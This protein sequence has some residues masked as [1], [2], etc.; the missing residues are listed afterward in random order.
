MRR[1]EFITL[2]G[3]AAVT[4]IWSKAVFAQTTSISRIAALLVGDEVDS[5][6]HAWVAAIEQG[7]RTAGRTAGV[8][9]RLDYYWAG[10]DP[11][12]AAVAAALVAKASPSVII[13]VGSA[14]AIAM[15]RA[16]STIPIVFSFASDPVGQGFVSNL[17]R[18]GGNITGFSNLEP[19][20]GG[21]LLGLLKE[22]APKTARVAVMFNPVTSPHTELFERSVG[23]A[24]PSF[25]IEVTRAP[26]YEDP[27]I[28]AVFQR[29]AA[30]PNGALL[31]PS[32]SFTFFRRKMILTLAA[33]HRVPAIFGVSR[34]AYDG[35]LAG[36]GA[37]PYE[38]IRSAAAY[39]DRI[40]KGE[41][42]GDLPVQQPTKYTLVLNLKTAKALGITV[43][44]T[45]LAIADDVIE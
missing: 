12:R 1:R 13:T 11:Q 23:K 42:P 44:P 19:E 2:L 3:G 33:Q 8:D 32:D 35:G 17:A 27:E 18:P 20:I 14:A 29:I 15:H 31:V 7:L 41:K 39:A 24:A 37:D 10:T 28:E 40:L 30:A 16:T 4:V 26:V 45:L 34:F 43:P 21:K 38:Q 36:Y 5:E 6:S 25:N 22:L 9:M